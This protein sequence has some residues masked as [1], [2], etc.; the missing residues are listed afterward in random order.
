MSYAAKIEVIRLNEVIADLEARLAAKDEALC[1]ALVALESLSEVKVGPYMN[2]IGRHIVI[3]K[4]CLAAVYP[5]LAAI[6][7]AL[8]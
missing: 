1:V 3:D 7:K 2:D 5:A 6:R 4:H 8:A